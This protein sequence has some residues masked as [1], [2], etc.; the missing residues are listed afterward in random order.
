[1]AGKRDDIDYSEAPD[2]APGHNPAAAKS[3]AIGVFFTLLGAAALTVVLVFDLPVKKLTALLAAVGGLGVVMG[4]GMVLFPWT[5][6]MFALNQQDD[7]GKLFKAMP[8]IW[9]VWFVLSMAV[10]LGVMFAVLAVK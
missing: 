5:E 3:R 1:M 4:V 8:Q 6:A 10:M 9:K 7:F 2:G